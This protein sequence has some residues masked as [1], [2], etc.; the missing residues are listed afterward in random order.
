MRSNL[1]LHII[2]FSSGRFGYVG[3]SMANKI[4]KRGDTTFVRLPSN[5]HRPINGGCQ[6]KHCAAMPKPYTPMWD[7][8]AFDETGHSW[9]VHYPELET[10][11]RT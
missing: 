5:L 11:N 1:G 2:Q 6:C 7:T 8:L 3:S 9:P 10:E 4:I